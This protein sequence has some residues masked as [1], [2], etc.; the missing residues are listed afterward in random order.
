MTTRRSRRCLLWTFA[1]A[2]LAGHASAKTRITQPLSPTPHA[3]HATGTAKLVLKTGSS[4]RFSVRARHLPAGK[5]FDV[6]VNKVKVGTLATG[7]RGRGVARFSTSPRGHR[8]MLGFDPR[9][10]EVEVRDADT[11]ED[12]LDAEMPD[13]HPDSA[14]GCCLGDRDGEGETECEDLTAA[15]CAAHGG[16]ATASTRC[17]P[18][19]CGNPPP[20]RAVCCLAHGMAGAS[21]D[22]DAD[23]DCEDISASDCAARGGTAIQASS[24][25]S[26]PCE[27]VPPPQVAICCVPHGGESWCANL[28]TDHCEQAGGQVSGGTSCD[29][30]PCGGESGDHGER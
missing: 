12:D 27:P 26:N 5:S 1:L 20:A 2:L 16:T 10:T 3:P 9:G 15:E 6:V 8:A 22:D 23:V 18:D 29:P 11:G 13:D 14:I 4:G 25:D 7:P 24:C 21:E 19:P 17:L 28:T 30:D